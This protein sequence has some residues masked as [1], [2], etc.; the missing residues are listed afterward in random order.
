MARQVRTVHDMEIDEISLVDRPANPHARVAIAKRATQEDAV[1]PDEIF[2]ESGTEVSL[3]DL[4]LGDV[5]YDAE[6]NAF[7]YTTES[8]PEGDED[9]DPEP[10]PARELA[11][12][13]KAFTAK[14]APVSKSLADEV[15]ESLAKAAT[16][17]DRDE[18][19]AKALDEITKADQRAQAAETIAKAERT[20]RLEREYIA[21]AG[22]YNVPIEPGELGPVLMRMAESMSFEDCSVIHKA[23]TAAGEMLFAEAGFSGQADNADPMQQIE[24]Y[25]DEARVAKSGGEISKHQ[26]ITD[27]FTDNPAAYDEYVASLNQP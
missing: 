12:V 23:L 2:D 22:E 10:E 5:V 19:I 18:V 16:D 14:P 6:G 3:D 17:A 15:R 25:L 9:P 4:E 24:A 13:S 8:D 26:A 1:P 21:K 20:L 11:G 27:F 7:R